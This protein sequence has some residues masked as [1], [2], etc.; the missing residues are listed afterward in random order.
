MTPKKVNKRSAKVTRTT[1]ETDIRLGLTIEG[2]GKFAITTGI[3][4]MDHMLT[5]MAAHGF[6]DLTLNAK[7]DIEIDHHHT[8]EDLGMVI[9]EAFNKALG[10]RKGIKRYGR[11]VVPMDEALASVVIDFSNRPFLVYHVNFKHETTGRFDA[12][13]IQ[14]FFRAFVNRS[15]ATLHINVMYGEN[16]HHIIEAVFKAFGQALDEASM[17]DKRIAEV[18]STKGIL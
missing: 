18:R 2:E 8:V 5:L 9:G 10:D 6:F 14:E 1:K 4:F 13:L 12:Q 15:G 16:T 7:G 3:P 11:G 17:L